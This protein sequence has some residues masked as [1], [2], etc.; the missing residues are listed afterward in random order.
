[1]LLE[2]CSIL[3]PLCYYCHVNYISIINL[4]TQFIKY[5]LIWLVFKSDRKRTINKNMLSLISNI[6]NLKKKI[7]EFELQAS[8]LLFHPENKN[9]FSIS[10]REGLLVMNPLSICSSGN[11]LISS[12]LEDSFAGCSITDWQYFHTLN[13]A[14][15]TLWF[16]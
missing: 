7:Y 16:P 11:V 15:N 4:S 5:C 13:V 12:F 6:Y 8:V 14:S 10:G 2:L 1:M 3:T 9:P